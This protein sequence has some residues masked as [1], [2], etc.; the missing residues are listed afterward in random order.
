MWDVTDVVWYFSCIQFSEWYNINVWLLFCI[1]YETQMF[2]K[3]IILKKP[4]CR[5]QVKR[6][7]HEYYYDLSMFHNNQVQNMII[8]Y[9]I[10]KMHL[11]Y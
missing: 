1:F 3:Q 2:K 11:S 9:V 8:D 4:F 5:L 6:W 10:I 7:E